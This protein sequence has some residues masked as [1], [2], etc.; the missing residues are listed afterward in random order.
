MIEQLRHEINLIL[1]DLEN[2]TVL[3]NVEGKMRARRL[4]SSMWNKNNNK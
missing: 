4:G 2:M 1:V 3:D